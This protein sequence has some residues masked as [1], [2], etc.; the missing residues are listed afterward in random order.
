MKYKKY[1]ATGE[2]DFG[3]VRNE[4]DRNPIVSRTW[5]IKKTPCIEYHESLESLS[6]DTIYNFGLSLLSSVNTFDT[7]TGEVKTTSFAAAFPFCIGLKDWHFISP[8]TYPIYNIY[9]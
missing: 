6:K 5:N 3:F 1:T 4:F 9:N 8:E 7:K 2:T